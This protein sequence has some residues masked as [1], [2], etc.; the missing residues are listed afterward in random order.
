MKGDYDGA[1]E[2]YNKAIEIDDKDPMK[3]KEDIEKTKKLAVQKEKARK[4]KMKGFLNKNDGGI[5]SE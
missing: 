4:Q 3:I 1:I 2:A 5:Y